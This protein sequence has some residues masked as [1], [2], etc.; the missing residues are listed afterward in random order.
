MRH[1]LAA[2]CLSLAALAASAQ[3]R[4]QRHLDYFATYAPLAVAEMQTSR[5]PASITLA[6]GLLE[7][8]AGESELARRSNNHFGIKCPGGWTG[9]THHAKDDDYRG[10]RLVES[11]FRA[12]DHP[13]DSYA[14]HSAFLTGS[15]RYASLF[16]LEPHDYRGWARGLKKAG[17]ATSKTYAHRLIE[18]I[19]RYE[20]YRYDRFDGGLP[21][22]PEVLAATTVA[23]VA[24]ATPTAP[25][26]PARRPAAPAARASPGVP[27]STSGP[28]RSAGATA[29][30]T[31]GLVQT[32]ND[33]DYVEALPGETLAALAGRTGRRPR[34]LYRYNE[35]LHAG[36]R[37]TA[38]QR[39]FLQP[40]RSAYRGRSRHHR[41]GREETLQSVADRYGLATS[42]L[43]DRNRIGPDEEPR[44]NTRL[45]I[46]GRRRRTD[47]VRTQSAAARHRDIAARQARSED[48]GPSMASA[49]VPA[50]TPTP[51]P[52][53]TPTP[54]PATVVA[55]ASAAPPAPAALVSAARAPYVVSPGDTLYAI[56]RAHGVS[57]A[58]LRSLNGLASN[59]IRVG[60]RLR[61]GE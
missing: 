20:L 48:L 12:Y 34:E 21:V 26:R 17:Y 58:E 11:C 59:T 44:A 54:T 13:A 24:P 31:T 22:G 30:T 25:A 6:Q 43:R 35:T 40:K 61:L 49:P 60:Q 2:G 47:V 42:A 29:P 37:L 55:S 52:A 23:P 3:G 18:L 16:T 10:G 4:S 38:G 14:D 53:P 41:V 56:S 39:V 46:R 57:V 33:V 28:G 19:E 27:S 15:P 50:P 36:A 5:I 45:V 1:L 8:G 51:A 9:R 7:S 32:V